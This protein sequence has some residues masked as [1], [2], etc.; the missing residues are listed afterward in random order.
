MSISERLDL[1]E[2]EQR[3]RLRMTRSAALVIAI[4]I[5]P[6]VP[7]FWSIA[8]HVSILA[9]V[10]ILAQLSVIALSFLKDPRIC[11]HHFLIVQAMIL[12]VFSDL[13]GEQTGTANV[14][15]SAAVYPALLFELRERRSIVVGLTWSIMAFYWIKITD[16]NPLPW[17]EPAPPS[18]ALTLLFE[19]S[20]GAITFFLLIAGSLYLSYRH[21]VIEGVLQENIEALDQEQ[22]ARQ[23]AD[24]ANAAK[25]RFMATMSHELRTPLNAIIGYA[26]MIQ[27]EGLNTQEVDHE[28]I[29]S[30]A[31]RIERSGRHLLALIND[32][33]DLSKVESGKVDFHPERFEL[34]RLLLELQEQVMPAIEEN[35]NT[36]K[37]ELEPEFTELNTDRLKLKQILLNLLANAAKFTH[38]GQITLRATQSASH[39]CIEVE[40]EGIGIAQDAQA[41]IFEAFEQADSSTTR[42]Y[43]GTGLGLSL[44]RRLV[45]VLGGALEL[46]SE[47]GQGSC[48]KVIIPW[49]E[50][51]P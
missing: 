31:L 44:S 10:A 35:Q 27:E 34:K 39:L 8:V 49:R 2:Q 40:D 13:L 15:F 36:F 19:Y 6:Y 1:G 20:F 32:V 11:K 28:A 9:M 25:S 47:L 33:L 50:L 17:L 5:A 18:P 12:V 21:Q 26:E 14:L 45:S 38:Q 7:L 29:I 48:F 51:E 4:C 42:R 41:R 46:S 24:E 22:R 37:L 16:Y 43:G 3:L 30:D 23:E